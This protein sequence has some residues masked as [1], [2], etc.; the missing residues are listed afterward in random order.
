LQLALRRNDLGAPFAFRLSLAGH[1]P[2]HRLG[3]V[4]LLDFHRL[5]FNSPRVGFRIENRLELQVDLVACRQ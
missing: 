4:H 1:R 3:Q 5:H 2:L